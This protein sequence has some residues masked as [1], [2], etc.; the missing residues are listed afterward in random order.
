MDSFNANMQKYRRQLEKGSIKEAYRGLMDYFNTLRRHFEKKYPD[1][2]V[3]GSIYQ[4]YMDMTYFSFTPKSLLAKKLKIAIV[5]LHE[6]FRF[7]V[8]L[9]GYNKKI[10]KKYWE[11]IKDLNWM[12]Y[13]VPPSIKG[14]DSIIE[15]ILVDNPD[16]GSLKKLTDEI[17]SRTL[18]FI[19]DVENFLSEH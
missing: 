3:S 11:L 13:S 9:I 12:K 7:E 5:Y 8:W 1:H 17:E 16:F 10:Q 18:V 6:E 4:G 15:Y 14:V 2:F 19:G